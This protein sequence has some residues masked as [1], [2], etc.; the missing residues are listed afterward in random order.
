MPF[1]LPRMVFYFSSSHNLTNPLDE[2]S[3]GN[4]SP[5]KIEHS[6]NT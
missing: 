5:I 6:K 1:F 3:Q 4:S 2:N